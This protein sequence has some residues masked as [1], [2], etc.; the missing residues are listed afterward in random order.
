[1]CTGARTTEQS[2]DIVCK[3]TGVR[4][5]ASEPVLA[6]LQEL[7]RVSRLEQDLM[8]AQEIIVHIT[9]EEKVSVIEN[10]WRM[11]DPERFPISAVLHQSLVPVTIF[12]D[13]AIA[14]G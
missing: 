12:S 10:A 3:A 2:L 7:R 11:A 13:R 6:R 9:G 5:T 8:K 14:F 4:P 1:M